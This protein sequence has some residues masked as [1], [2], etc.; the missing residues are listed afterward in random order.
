M[1]FQIL[2]CCL[3]LRN[4]NSD[5]Q[6]KNRGFV[7]IDQM[8]FD[9]MRNRDV[10]HQ[11]YIKYF[12]HCFGLKIHSWMDITP[13]F[14]SNAL[15][16]LKRVYENVCD[17]ELMVGMLL[18]KRDETVFGKTSSCIVAEQFY[19]YKYGDRFFYSNPGSPYPFTKRK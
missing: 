1:F 15:E 8:F 19:R 2:C 16:V 6:Y 12:E 14:D 10:G 11:P 4:F 7:G 5:T 17:I 18:E 3:Q 13:Y 9:I